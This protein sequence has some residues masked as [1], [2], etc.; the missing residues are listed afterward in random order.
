MSHFSQPN[1]ERKNC[2]WTTKYN[3]LLEMCRYCPTCRNEKCVYNSNEKTTSFCDSKKCKTCCNVLNIPF[4][5]QK[6]KLFCLAVTQHIALPDR[7]VAITK[8]NP[9]L[10]CRNFFANHNETRLNLNQKWQELF[11]FWHNRVDIPLV[12]TVNQN[13]IYILNFCK[14]P[15]YIKAT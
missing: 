4:T 13:F 11:F 7:R 2:V 1:I 9:L 5:D 12:D 10:F 6:P 3:R 15:V 8:K 14:L